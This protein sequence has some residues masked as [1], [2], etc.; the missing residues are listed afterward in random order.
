VVG[1]VGVGLVVLGVEV[2]LAGVVKVGPVILGVELALWW[3]LWEWDRSSLVLSWHCGGYCGSGTV[4][5][6]AEMALLGVI[7]VGL[8]VLGVEV[9][10][11]GVVG[12]E[13]VVLGVEMAMWWVLWEWE[14][15]S[16]VL[17]WH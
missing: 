6:G 14:W 1:T 7:E 4:V 2:T 3:V 16:L 9:T 11:A 13:L 15:S 12:V 17:T 8:V 5:L 10:L